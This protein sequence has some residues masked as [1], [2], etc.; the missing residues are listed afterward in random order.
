MDSENAI[1]QALYDFEASFG[2]ELSFKAGDVL[3]VSLR[4]A[5][6]MKL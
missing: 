2:D 5:K 4:E 3:K 1:V 6:L